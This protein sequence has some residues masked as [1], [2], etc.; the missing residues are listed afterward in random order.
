MAA[1]LNFKMVA[2]SNGQLLG[3]CVL[4]ENTHSIN[5]MILLRYKPF[6][7]LIT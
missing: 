6:Q 5:I 3:A 4:F 2:N 1:I 7:V